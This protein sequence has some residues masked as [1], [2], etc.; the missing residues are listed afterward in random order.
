M[1]LVSFLDIHSGC[2]F[3]LTCTSFY[4]DRAELSLSRSAVVFQIQVGDWEVPS[5]PLESIGPADG[6]WRE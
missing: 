3:L 5:P 1:L 4:I 2:R 6:V